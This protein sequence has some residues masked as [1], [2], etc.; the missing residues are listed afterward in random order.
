MLS[1]QKGKDL[2]VLNILFVWSKSVVSIILECF[3][4]SLPEYKHWVLVGWLVGFIL[5]F[6]FCFGV[7]LF[8]FFGVCV[9][10]N[11]AG[12]VSGVLLMK[13]FN[14][15]KASSIKTSQLYRI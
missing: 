14:F 8:C 1:W 6:C 3:L 4:C 10:A 9:Q 11:G 12:M 2:V 15:P 7:V 5:G 13:I